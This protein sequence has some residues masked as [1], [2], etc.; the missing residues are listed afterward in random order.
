MDR[1]GGTEPDITGEPVEQL[2]GLFVSD[3][4][5]WRRHAP[6]MLDRI[7]TRL[8]QEYFPFL[9][10][11][12]PGLFGGFRTRPRPLLVHAG[13]LD[14]D[15]NSY[16]TDSQNLTIGAMIFVIALMNLPPVDFRRARR[17]LALPTTSAHDPSRR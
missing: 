6:D 10:G 7:R 17:S 14:I 12:A 1:I 16:S 11:R 13:A 5:R 15:L 4:A 3:L 2:L 8:S 9:F